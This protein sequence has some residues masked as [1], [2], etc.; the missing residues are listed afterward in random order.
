MTGHAYEL[1][2]KYY[3][4]KK[5][6]ARAKLT[7]DKTTKAFE[8]AGFDFRD[9][10]WDLMGAKIARQ[11][12]NYKESSDLFDKYLNNM[13]TLN[14]QADEF[15][16]NEYE[17][18]LKLNQSQMEKNELRIQAEHYKS[19]MLVVVIA[20]IL[21]VFIAALI[22][23]VLL[24]RMNVQL[25]ASNEELKE[26]YDRVDKLNAMKT[27]FIQN[28]S[29]EIRT[30]LNS[31]VGFSQLLGS[32]K[33]EYKQYSYI[34]SENS[35]NLT[36][37]VNNVLEISDL[38]S[39]N[40]ETSAMSVNDCCNEAL[41]EIKVRMPSSIN[42]TYEP[43]DSKLII[44]SNKER[45]EQVI[46][47]LLDNA[48]KFTKK[49]SV[50]FL[51]STDGKKV[52]FSVTDT[53]PSIPKDKVDWVFEKFTKLDEFEQGSGLGLPVCKTI[54]EKLGGEI[55]IDTTYQNGCKVDFWLPINLN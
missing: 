3:L 44:E 42:L 25:K 29:H 12:G 22:V 8:E 36:K 46:I 9:N 14:H 48:I 35:Y 38:E 20:V 1:Q 15:R 7:L 33:G 51:Y 50:S 19:Q 23:I 16:T 5:D 54:I 37:I 13:D 30:P 32:I 24:H 21:L 43:Q 39:C 17:V 41:D 2:T 31:I 27:S 28:M 10:K 26:A 34:I 18:Q 4:K 52:F 53:G 40:I 49:G 45:L 55:H 11:M 47:N 6:Y